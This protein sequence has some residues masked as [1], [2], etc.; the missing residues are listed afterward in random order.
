MQCVM[1]AVQDIPEEILAE[2]MLQREECDRI[3]LS[4]DTLIQEF[5]RELR[6]K[7]EVSLRCQ[8]DSTECGVPDLCQISQEASRGHRYIN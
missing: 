2:M 1:V 4:K 8:I 5:E 3:V 7:D 6:H